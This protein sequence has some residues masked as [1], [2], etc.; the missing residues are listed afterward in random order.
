MGRGVMEDNSLEEVKPGRLTG[1]RLFWL[2]IM[3]VIVLAVFLTGV[4]LTLYYKSGSAQLDLSR[5]SYKDVRSQVITKEETAFKVEGAG[6]LDDTFINEFKV[7]Y[8]QQVQKATA[9]DS[10]AGDPLD[11]VQLW[12]FEDDKASL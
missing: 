4:S 5:P 1:F 10:F 8:S 6:A 7:L 12:G 2:M 9:V 3:A 11:P